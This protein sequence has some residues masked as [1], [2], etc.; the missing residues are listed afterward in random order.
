MTGSVEEVLGRYVD[1]IHPL[2]RDDFSALSDWAAALDEPGNGTLAALELAAARMA[3][4]DT[5]RADVADRYGIGTNWVSQ[6]ATRLRAESG[7]D[8]DFTGIPDRIKEAAVA[9]GEEL[10][11]RRGLD[12]GAAAREAAAP[13]GI[14]W[15]RV[16][17]AMDVE[18]PSKYRYDGTTER[19]LGL[20]R[21]RPQ[22]VRELQE[23]AATRSSATHYL[24]HHEDRFGR[25]TA[26]V[27]PPKGRITVW[28]PHGSEEAAETLMRYEVARYRTD[29]LDAAVDAL[30]PD[31]GDAGLVPD[32]DDWQATAHE[33]LDAVRDYREESPQQFSVL[34]AV[35]PDLRDYLADFDDRYDYGKLR[36]Y[37]D[38]RA[39]HA[40]LAERRTDLDASEDRLSRGL[41]YLDHAPVVSAVSD[42]KYETSGL[43]DAHVHLAAALVA[44]LADFGER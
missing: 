34:A 27:P 37:F 20:L 16:R 21:C 3:N 36:P 38:A 19:L 28:Y 11:A 30:A 12:K 33:T 41:S 32:P 31:R 40:Y 8:I 18:S 39:A 35:M 24:R 7:V 13:H 29:D 14:G 10:V 15:K 22:T 9:T 4:D 23:R 43:D 1:D 42:T 26:G 25:M 2:Y 44:D 5:E 6:S 17:D